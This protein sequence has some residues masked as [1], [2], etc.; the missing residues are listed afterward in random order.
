MNDGMSNKTTRNKRFFEL[1]GQCQNRLFSFL[2]MM[3]HNEADAEDLL[4]DTAAT[5]LEKFETYELGT[6]FTAWGMTIAKNKAI[7]FLR[8]NLKTRP[9]FRDD[10]YE[11]IAQLET[12]EKDTF[13]DRALAMETCLKRLEDPD[14][15]MLQMRYEQEYSMKKIAEVFGRSKTGIYHTMARIHNLLHNCIKLKMTSGQI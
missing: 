11:R 7:N 4:Q 5:M 1:Y 3:V 14:K 12:R 6:N 15:K 8:K 9:Q 13:S 10:F 2:F